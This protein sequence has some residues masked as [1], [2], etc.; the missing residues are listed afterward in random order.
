VSGATDLITFYVKGNIAH[1]LRDRNY[2]VAK[3]AVNSAVRAYLNTDVKSELEP[4]A[5]Y[6]RVRRRV[7]D[8]VREG[9]RG[10]EA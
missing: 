9:D 3:Y 6:V 1:S 10:V 5:H 4:L 2:A 8:A 7:E